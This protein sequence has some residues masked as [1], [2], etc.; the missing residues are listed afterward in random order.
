M[1]RLFDVLTMLF[2]KNPYLT[3]TRSHGREGEPT[4]YRMPSRTSGDPYDGGQSHQRSSFVTLS[5]RLCALCDSNQ[6]QSSESSIRTT[7]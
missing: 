4:R 3:R 7:G 5:V 1:N 2:Y 6:P